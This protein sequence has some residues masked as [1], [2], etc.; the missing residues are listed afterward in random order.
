MNLEN[1][2]VSTRLGIG[3]GCVLLLMACL[4]GVGL[5]YITDAS[6]LSRQIVGTD[7]F[8]AEAVTTVKIASQ[9]NARR[10]MELFFAADKAQAEGI[11]R[12]IETNQ[13][14]IAEALAAL[15]QRVSTDEEKTLMAS[16]Q[17]ARTVHVAAFG[18]GAK[19]LESGDREE[20]ARFF[21]SETLPALDRFQKEVGA[22]GNL[23]A[24]YVQTH[25]ERAERDIG[26]ARN[27]MLGLGLAA[28]LIG[29]A[30]VY[31]LGRT[32]VQ[33][34]NEAIYI[35]ETVA[36]GDLSQEFDSKR[37]GDFGHLLTVLGDMEDMLTDLVTRIK[38][39][40]DSLTVTSQEIALGNADLSQRTAGQ[41]ASLEE[42]VSS[43]EELTSTVKLNAQN[44]Q[45][46]S[47]LAASA[48]GIAEQ[49]GKV[50]LQVVETMD[51]ISGSSKKIVDIIGV[52]EGIAFQTNILA[53]N[54]AVEAARAGEQGRGFAVVAS[55]VRSLAQR[56][57]AAAK[58]IKTL[59]GDSVAHVDT[60]SKL[61]V[62]AG[63][64]MRDI[65]KAVQRVSQLLG[66]ISTA[67]VEQS[68]G[69]E[70]VSQAMMQMDQAT[71]QNAAMV[72]QASVAV[73]SLTEHAQR[74]QSA[75]GE[76]RLDAEP[77]G[78]SLLRLA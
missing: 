22:F 47:A 66:Q 35:A 65:V 63:R 24:R 15:E 59:I 69:I 44:A 39:S 75:V 25:G 10:T 62:Q 28:L 70:H 31:R 23:Q 57:A 4:I 16:L 32:M 6:T 51:S 38:A 12:Q 14:S 78:A 60:G 34:L 77:V 3:F 61:V 37:G 64:T 53:L 45:S 36:S 20:A 5:M 21:F 49:G 18:K 41:A 8:K 26:S 55:E 1:L 74:L 52:I 29:G 76:F 54:A 2:K 40:A 67:S 33:S 42:T 9:A 71:Q 73:A 11:R 68:I 7:W 56:S 46:A 48:A 13:Q 19:L 72:E 17:S 58:E 43:M 30:M 50:V 27:W